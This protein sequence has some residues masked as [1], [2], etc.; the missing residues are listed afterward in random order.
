MGKSAALAQV[1][2]YVSEH[3]GTVAVFS[4]EMSSRQWLL[5]IACRRARV[6]GLML[7]QGKTSAEQERRVLDE[8]ARLESRDTLYLDDTPQT[9]DDMAAACL[10]LARRTGLALV[11]TDHLRLFGDADE[12]ETRRLGTITWNHKKLAKS[13]DA[14]VIAA[15][16]L[17]RAVEAQGDKRPDLKDL[18]DSGEIEENADTVTAL[19][20]DSYYTEKTNDR[21]AEFINRK[22]REGERNARATFVFQPE[23]TGFETLAIGV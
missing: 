21:T 17:S 15:A 2:D 16:Q 22:A 14:A 7:R 10:R 11:I 9:T 5:R 13:L 23:Y 1:S 4:L 18:R 19:Y 3:V 8:L 12:R 20:R 6:S